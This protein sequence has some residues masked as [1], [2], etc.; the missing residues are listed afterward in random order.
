[1]MNYNILRIIIIANQNIDESKKNRD[2]LLHSISIP[3][4]RCLFILK[5]VA[6]NIFFNFCV[7]VKFQKNSDVHIINYLGIQEKNI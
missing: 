5:M 4:T 1:M 2:T 7:K 3:E 6:N